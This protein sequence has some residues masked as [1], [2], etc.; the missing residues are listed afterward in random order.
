MSRVNWCCSSKKGIIFFSSLSCEVLPFLSAASEPCC[1]IFYLRICLVLLFAWSVLVLIFLTLVF[2]TIMKGS[3]SL[4]L[5]SMYLTSIS[6]SMCSAFI[7]YYSYTYISSGGL[8]VF[9]ER[10]ARIFEG[11]T[12]WK[13]SETK[14]AASLGS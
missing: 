11:C 6:S 8:S 2:L 7:F 13:E 10:R 5:S 3:S 12:A 1:V 4:E 14:R 9:S